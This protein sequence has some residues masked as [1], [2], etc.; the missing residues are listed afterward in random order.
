LRNIGAVEILE[1]YYSPTGAG[2]CSGTDSNPFYHSSGDTI[3]KVNLSTG[4]A[5][6]KAALAAA[7][8]M[9]GPGPLPYAVYIPWVDN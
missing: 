6:T 8:S 2:G 5:I 1:N 4:L 3:D 7:F 9:A